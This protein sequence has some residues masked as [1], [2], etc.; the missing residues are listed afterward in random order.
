MSVGAEYKLHY[1]SF[2][3]LQPTEKVLR[4][5]LGSGADTQRCGVRGSLGGAARGQM[6]VTEP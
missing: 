4:V 6:A 3:A 1:V 2:S 5:F